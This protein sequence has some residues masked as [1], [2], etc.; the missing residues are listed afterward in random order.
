MQ[1][2]N[3][4]PSSSIDP[5][6]YSLRKRLPPRFPQRGNDVY[7]SEKTNFRA[8]ES[9]CQ[10]LLDSGNEVVIHGLGKAVNRAINLALQLKAKG[11]GTIKLAIQ[12]ST[13][14]LIDDLMPETDD[15]EAK[16]LYRNNSAVHI[17]VYRSED[18]AQSQTKDVPKPS[19]EK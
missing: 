15:G 7:I 3:S 1:A 18:S 13:V 17:C 19:Q 14:N 5:E 9:K 4:K 11:N 8:Q 6:E 12:T 2:S 10:K 16:T